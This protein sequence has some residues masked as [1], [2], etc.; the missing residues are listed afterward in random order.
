[1]ELND[2]ADEGQESLPEESL[3][4]DG[5]PEAASSSDAEYTWV[6]VPAEKGGNA[7]FA[8]VS[9]AEDAVWEQEG[10][11]GNA[12]FAPEL[13]AGDAVGE[14]HGPK[15][16]KTDF[17]MIKEAEIIPSWVDM[18][19]LEDYANADLQTVDPYK[20]SPLPMQKNTSKKNAPKKNTP[21]KAATPKKN[22]P[23]K[24]AAPK[25]KPKLNKENCK[26]YRTRVQERNKEREILIQKLQKENEIFWTLYEME[27]GIDGMFF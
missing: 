14:L 27:C 20:I 9:G 12:A 3:N 19:Q 13:G 2:V 5:G 22:T 23:K 16:S 26:N 24:A 4:L 8:P 1:L 6:L 15:A 18:S 11:G 7:D 17:D 10:E 25:K 21:K